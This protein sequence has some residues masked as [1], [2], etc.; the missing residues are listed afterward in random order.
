[1]E[2]DIERVLRGG[3]ASDARLYYPGGDGGGGRRQKRG[4]SGAVVLP[5]ARTSSRC[6][7]CTKYHTTREHLRHARGGAPMPPRAPKAAR[8]AK[9][10]RRSKKRPKKKARG[11]AKEKPR[12]KAP[13]LSEPSQPAPRKTTGGVRRPPVAAV[14]PQAAIGIV[15]DAVRG[16]PV[17]GRFGPEKV[18]VSEIWDRVGGRL[19]MSLQQFK[20]W[21][22]DRNRAGDLTLARADLV[23]AMDPD[24]VRRSEIDVHGATFHFVLD[25]SAQLW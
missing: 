21:L 18:F 6:S 24:Q 20:A 15:L 1:M 25:R 8:T 5:H 10:G 3:A 7:L 19:G 16:M 12:R 17:A 13:R 14:A 11:P 2:E 9:A 23:G 4:G 22:V